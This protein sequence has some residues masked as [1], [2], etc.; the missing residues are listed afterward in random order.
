M[1]SD[2]RKLQ[3]QLDELSRRLDGMYAAPPWPWPHYPQTIVQPC[4]GPHYPA[5]TPYVPWQP[6]IIWSD[7]TCGGATSGA[8]GGSI[9]GQV[10][11]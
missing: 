1:R 8:S 3:R 11:S 5:T 6:N 7:R 9:T 10:W 2:I 4:P